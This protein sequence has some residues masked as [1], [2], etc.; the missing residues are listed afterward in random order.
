MRRVVVT[1][2]GLVTPLGIGKKLSLS[3]SVTIHARLTYENAGV[4]RTWQRLIDGHCGITSTRDKGP[5]FAVLPSQVAAVVPEGSRS[6]GKWNA[7][8][9]LAAGVGFATHLMCDSHDA[10]KLLG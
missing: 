7:K 1:G 5:Q 3:L 10:L 4:R 2:L 6:D 8:D 9:F